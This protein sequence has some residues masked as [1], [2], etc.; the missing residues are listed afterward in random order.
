MVET[1]LTTEAPESTQRHLDRSF[2]S[3]LAWTGMAKWGV[4]LLT[5]GSTLVVVRLLTPTDYGIMGMATMFL[6]LIQLISEFGLGTALV[7]RRSLTDSQ[8]SRI[9]G[10][11]ILI[12]IGLFGLCASLAPAVAAFFDEPRVR[13]VVVILSAMFVVTG[14]R[15]LPA[16]LLA[17]DMAFRR[18]A[19]IEA[20][21]ALTL[22]AVTLSLAI[23]GARYWA[24]VFGGVV[25]KVVGT[26]LLSRARPHRIAWPRDLRSLREEI[27]FGWRVAVSKVAWYAYSNADFAI[28]GRVLGTAQLGLYTFGWTISSIPVD[29]V[30]GVLSRVTF[31][32]LSA[33]QHDRVAVARYLALL[34]EGLTIVLMP[35]SIGLALVAPDFVRV[36]LGERWVPAIVPLQAL[37]LVVTLRCLMPIYPTALLALD[38]A[39][40]NMWVGIVQLL[41]MPPAFYVGARLGGANG[42]AIA[43]LVAYPIIA[44]PL[45]PMYVMRRINMPLRR[46]L[47]AIWPAA[48]STAGMVLVVLLLQRSLSDATGAVRLAATVAAGAATYGAV[49]MQLHRTRLVAIVASLRAL[50][51]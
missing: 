18:L 37:S 6:G 13:A 1:P 31:P 33:V 10:L 43:W 3:G 29:K 9:G 46:M 44:I 38:D 47:L 49:M 12:G 32:V 42:V 23:G 20:T 41:V 40:H 26:L 36:V 28:I 45:F 16:S 15:V 27:I 50:R 4:Q 34:T 8:V 11:A 21:E 17:R 5:W 51:G 19:L 14:I 48:S 7:Q 22:T 24:L 39:K 35:A 2:A 30:S 25:S